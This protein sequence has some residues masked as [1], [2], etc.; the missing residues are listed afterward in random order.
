M[1]VVDNTFATPYLQRPL[2]FGADAVVHSTT[3]Y[4]GGHS[5]VVGGARRHQRRATWISTCG[6]YRTP[7]GAVPGPWDCYL[8][9]RGA[10]TLA[11][12]MDRHCTNAA[13]IVDLLVDH[14]AVSSVMYP[15]LETHPHHDVAARQMSGFGGMVSFRAAGGRDAAMRIIESTRIFTLAESLGAVES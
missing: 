3:K 2:R 11:V 9:L 10:K 5:D 1:F 15:G 14:P 8:T 12:R 13:A 4:L 7:S 6:S